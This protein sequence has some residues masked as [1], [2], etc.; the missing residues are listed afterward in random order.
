MYDIVS[1]LNASK[2]QVFECK[3]DCGRY[4]SYHCHMQSHSCEYCSCVCFICLSSKTSHTTS[5]CYTTSKTTT[6]GID[7]P[8]INTSVTATDVMTTA[9]DSPAITSMEAVHDATIA[10]DDPGAITSGAVDETATAGIDVPA[11]NT[12]GTATDVMVAADA[13]P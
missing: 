8:A 1:E 2:T 11:V 13:S 10:N 4:L 6:A 9:D 7:V 12:S 3:Q 5:K